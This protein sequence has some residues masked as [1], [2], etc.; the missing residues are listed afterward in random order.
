MEPS[1]LYT[2]L[3]NLQ[4]PQP[5]R[6]LREPLGDLT[7][8]IHRPSGNKPVKVRGLAPFHTLEDIQ[9]ALW[10][11]Q[12]KP[13]DLYPKFCYLAYEHEEEMIPALYTPIIVEDGDVTPVEL[14]EPMT[15]VQARN[16]QIAFVDEDGNKLPVNPNPRGRVS[17]DD[18][19]LTPMGGVPTLHAYPLQGLLSAFPGPKPMSAKDWYGLFYPYF[20][21]LEMNETGQMTPEETEIAGHLAEFIAAKLAQVAMLDSLRTAVNLR[22]FTTTGVRFIGLQWTKREREEYFGGLDSLFFSADVNPTRPFMR[23]ISANNTPITKLFQPDPLEPPQV[24]DPVL[25]KAW[26]DEPNPIACASMLFVKTLIRRAEFGMKPL[27]GTLRVCED[28]TAVFTIEPP[29]DQRILDFRKDLRSLETILT[30]ITEDMPFNV[31]TVRLGAASLRIEATFESALPKG[32]QKQIADRISQL[33]TLFQPTEQ[34]VDEQKTFLS[35][36]YKG[37]SNFFTADRVQSYLNY[38]YARKPME[39]ERLGEDARQLAR[40]FQVSEDEA[41]RL[42]QSYLDKT[43]QVTTID[44]DATEFLVLNNPGIDVSL[45]VAS[46]NSL[47]IHLF[48]IRAV[49]IDDIRR[50]CTVLGLV[51][52][53]PELGWQAALRDTNITK[54]STMRAAVA[55]VV[56]EREEKEEE[57]AMEASSDEEDE[58]GEG[59]FVAMG[60]AE[61]DDEDAP[62]PRLPAAAAQREIGAVDQQRIVAQGWFNNRLKEL[63][64]TLF[65]YTG[66]K[67]G[68]KTQQYSTKCPP[69]VDRYPFALTEAQYQN[70]RRIYAQKEGEKKVA[71]IVYGVPNTKETIDK[72]VGSA[73][74]I[75]VLR[76]GS[77][78]KNLFYFLCMRILCLKDLMPILEEDW[79]SRVDY[80]GEPKPKESCPFCH[81]LEIKDRHHAQEG[82]T[83]FIRKNAPRSTEAFTHIGFLSKPEHP[84]GY[85]LPCCFGKLSHIS[86]DDR[87]KD[88]KDAAQKNRTAVEAA[89]EDKAAKEAEKSANLEDSLRVRE[90]LL[91]DYSILRHK[92]AKEYVLG[93]VKYPLDPGKVGLPSLQIDAFFGQNSRETVNRVA[94]KQEFKPTARGFYRVGVNNKLTF[95]N[96]SLFSALGPMLGINTIKGVQD[97][98]A[99]IITPR[100]FI[101]LNFGNLVLEFFDPTDPEPSDSVLATWAQKHLLVPNL[102]DTLFEISRYYRS[103]HRFIAYIYDA[104]QRKQMRH[105]AHALAEIHHDIKVEDGTST[106]VGLT[107]MTLHYKGD[108][109]DENTPIE[110]LCP[111]EGIDINRYANNVVGFMT[112]SDVGV[113]EP[114]F[115]LNELNTFGTAR[116]DIRYVITQQDIQDPTFPEVARRRYVD[117]FIVRCRSA[118]RGA[119]TLQSGVD[120]RALVPLSKAIDVLQSK[121]TGLV[122]DVYNHIVAVTVANPNK[123]KADEI[124]VPV[125]DDGNSFHDNTSLKIHLGI[126]SV[127]LASANDVYQ[128]YEQIITPR[129]YPISNVYKISSFLNT[130][131]IVGF[132]LGGADSYATVLLPC[133]HQATEI[134]AEIIEQADALKTKR[135]GDYMFEYVL[136]HEIITMPNHETYGDSDASAFVLQRKQ[137]DILYEHFRLAF[138]TWISGRE[139]RHLRKFIE[140]TCGV[141]QWMPMDARPPLLP[142]YIKMYRLKVVLASELQKWF[143]ANDEPIDTKNIVLRNDCIAIDD[144]EEKCTGACTFV[145][146]EDGDGKCKIHVPREVQVRSTPRP[147]SQPAAEYFINRLFDEIIRMPYK[148]SELLTK[149]VKRLQVPST[150]IHMGTQWIVPQNVPAWYELLRDTSKSE[151]E[152]PQFYEEFSRSEQS[153]EEQVGLEDERRLYPIPAALAALLP[154]NAV[155]KLAL[156]VIGSRGKPPTVSLRRYFGIRQ[157]K[158]VIEGATDMTT[159]VL[160]EISKKYELPIIQVLLRQDPVSIIGITESTYYAVKTGAYVIVPDFEEGP[161]IVVMRDDVADTVP[162]KLIEGRLL[163]SIEPMRYMMVKRPK[164]ARS[165][166]APLAED[167]RENS[168]E[169]VPQAPKPRKIKLVRPPAPA[170]PPPPPLMAPE[171]MEGVD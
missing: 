24:S 115:F 135:S 26:A 111:L 5:L 51:F 55:S 104:N 56:V 3:Q 15:T 18:V 112:Y 90:Q 85:E 48:N 138:S 91:V 119:F 20:P 141:K 105:F 28:T 6:N 168:V 10:H 49:S 167:V 143:E 127:N 25:L 17:I 130:N 147:T 123:A 113:W 92:L 33:N 4:K 73:E 30:E 45:S 84:N 68:K 52:Y 165:A 66:K 134:P 140:K 98:F 1:A 155:D 31:Q 151:T 96:Q 38:L 149:G 164:V 19:F 16:H 23:L 171:N 9:R 32:I 160:T 86:F 62:A 108:P 43:G 128:A 131:K 139:T 161:A 78:P 89:I 114:L 133:G 137:V 75:T 146:D 124:L 54:A 42:I 79:N 74:K 83:V 46:M 88:I 2:V 44:D 59:V 156:E 145:K 29:K 102:Q 125:V 14:S 61:S 67:T 95:L 110:V 132:R 40:E 170:P 21:D 63:D 97:Y 70:M 37:V 39:L 159:G 126:K 166:A 99:N 142:S 129:L 136:N 72:A 118:H 34:L 81:G 22:E 76:Y 100:I 144:D 122:R 153:E 148:R 58:S 71:F 47:N 80:N 109:R 50:V 41:G 35:F 150:D 158:Y 27:Y 106:F 69:A 60:A 65:G 93:H 162:A 11:Q 94:I 121:V 163:E 117:E 12:N 64:K 82:H 120:N 169:A 8:I 13:D 77:D 154:R 7:V 152:Q 103:Y 53:T 157:S 57:D 36:R 107:I 101:N 87:F 116:S